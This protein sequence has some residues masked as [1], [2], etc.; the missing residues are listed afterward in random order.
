MLGF[1]GKIYQKSK[2]VTSLN[3]FFD[4]VEEA[5][6]ILNTDDI[7]Y[8]G[9]PNYDYKLVPN[10]YRL[11][12]SIDLENKLKNAF[13]DKAKGFINWRDLSDY[14]WY[15]LMQHFGIKTRLLDWTE[16]FLIALFFALRLNPLD[17]A[18]KNPSIWMINP[19]K[20][21][22]L[23]INKFELIRTENSNQNLN[24]NLSQQY[25]T[26]DFDKKS[27]GPIAISSSYT[28]ERIIRQKGCFTLHG[29]SQ[30]DI[31]SVYRKNKCNEILS[32]NIDSKSRKR[33]TREL[34]TTGISESTIFPDLEGLAREVNFKYTQ[35]NL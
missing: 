28:N 23:S 22:E 35:N 18:N 26:F 6:T 25:L 31:L 17:N 32:I 3:Q 24:Y 33:L 4:L 20:L 21:N 30:N 8:R 7:W 2:D 9:H 16:G 11:K 15:F 14:D 19:L 34:L 12:H 29:N 10:I 27:F 13:T 5:K 1:T